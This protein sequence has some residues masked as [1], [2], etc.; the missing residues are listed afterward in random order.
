MNKTIKYTLSLLSDGEI[1]SGLGNEVVNDVLARDH[2]GRPVLRG[3]HIKGLL[4]D[5][6]A[7]LGR[8]RGWPVVLDELCFGREGQDGDDGIQGHIRISDACTQKPEAETRTITRTHLTELGVASGGSLRTTEAVAAGTVFQGKVRL[9]AA[10]PEAVE[11]ALR[12]SMLSLEAVGGGRSRGGGSCRVDVE[13]EH[14]SPGE[15]LK[16]LQKLVDAGLRAAEPVSCGPVVVRDPDGAAVMLRLVFRAEDPVCCPE[17]PIVGNNVVRTGLGIPA[18]AV[19]GLVIARLAKSDA[20]LADGAL[21]DPRTRAWPLLPSALESDQAGDAPVSV[22]VALSHR[23]S[24]LANEA[25]E[26]LFKDAAIDPYDW[27]D[28]P[29]GSPLKGADGVLLLKAGEKIKLWKSG[30]MPRL[31]T[32][33]S[34]HH[35]ERNLFTVE[36]MAPR[37]YSGWI[38]LPPRAAGELVKMLK[39]DSSVVFGKARTVRGGGNLEASPC[40]LGR[41]VSGW[42]D[43]VFVLQAPAAIPDDWD[44]SS[45]RAESVLARLVRESGWG[46]LATL[47][48]E[49]SKVEIVSHGTCGVRF[50]WN[51]HGYGRGVEQTR[52]L[53]ARR[54]FLPGTVFVL[55]HAPANLNS[56]LIRGLG[57]EDGGDVDGRSQGFG[58]VLPHPGIARERMQSTPRFPVLVSDGAG[59]LALGWVRKSGAIS[60]SASQIGAVAER[61]DIQDGGRKALEYLDQQKNRPDRI[62]DRW[63]PVWD[64]VVKTIASNPEKAKKALR[65]WQDLAIVN[66][67]DKEV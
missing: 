5:R 32:G 65:T 66:R 28:I 15:I 37:V 4:R 27:R 62:W 36:A 47:E 50:G 7:S 58:A 53:K 51:R 18:S 39:E 30:D 63:K 43:K 19:L 38:S 60:P 23:M 9:D 67:K 13:N 41:E 29:S 56:Q 12:L 44:I 35:V 57:V 20:G 1:G 31:V 17:T 25:G 33:H 61:V 6:L 55:K 64:D 21:A 40:D 52:R 34:V 16:A 8:D 59:Q 2:N 26:Y 54:V 48:H 24:K 10:A 14:R 3:S 11:L 49:D 45:S 22:R 46:E 42:K